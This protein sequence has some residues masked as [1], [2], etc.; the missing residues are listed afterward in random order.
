MIGVEPYSDNSWTCACTSMTTP[1]R[2]PASAP[3]T[4]DDP[5]VAS[6]MV[7]PIG[8]PPDTDLTAAL[9]LMMSLGLRHLPVIEAGGR[10]L[11]V[12]AES[13]L[14]RCL[15]QGL[16]LP[17]SGW[18]RV[19]RLV[20]RVEPIPSTARRSDAARQMCA[21][22]SD[23]VLVMD[24]N[25]LRGIVTA[26]DV[27]RSLGRPEEDPPSRAVNRG[28]GR[29]KLPCT[30]TAVHPGAGDDHRMQPRCPMSLN[31]CAVLCQQ[32]AT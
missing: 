26:T 25:G 7:H 31:R 24:G 1:Q 30:G 4:I 5:A 27:L 16:G 18:L 2:R 3:E 11:G 9:R 13:E 17:Y 10:C 6:I 14:V 8:I 22:G 32:S 12:V 19:G 23:V 21:D 20:R 29:S 15:A 28:C